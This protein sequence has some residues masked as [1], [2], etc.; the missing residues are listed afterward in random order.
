MVGQK[1]VRDLFGD[2]KKDIEM[3]FCWRKCFVCGGTGRLDLMQTRVTMMEDRPI[4]PD[5]RD[6]CLNCKGRGQIYIKE[7]PFKPWGFF[8]KDKT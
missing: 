8:R 7:S 6:E 3:A 2:I 1:L 5:E 4:L